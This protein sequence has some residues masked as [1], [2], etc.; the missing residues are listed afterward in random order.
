[1]TRPEFKDD[2]VTKAILEKGQCY[3]VKPSAKKSLKNNYQNVVFALELKGD[4]AMEMK[5]L[6]KGSSSKLETSKKK[7]FI[8]IKKGLVITTAADSFSSLE[9]FLKFYELTDIQ[10]GDFID[11]YLENMDNKQTLK[12][13][14]APRPKRK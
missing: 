14:P 13:K 3:S 4:L 5:D 12:T 7:G 10:V 9:N 8:E 11:E 2:Y 1:M 6:S